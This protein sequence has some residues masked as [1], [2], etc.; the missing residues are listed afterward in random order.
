MAR[1]PGKTQEKKTDGTPTTPPK[2]D[3]PGDT[4]DKPQGQN[5]PPD[6]P[7]KLGIAI[8][9]CDRNW[10]PTGIGFTDFVAK[11]YKCIG[12][13]GWVECDVDGPITFTLH[14]ASNLAG[15]CMNGGKEDAF[16]PDLW[17]SKDESG[18]AEWVYP[19]D[20]G[21]DAPSS[22]DCESKIL[23][24]DNEPGHFHYQWIK[25]KGVKNEAKVT[26]R[27]EDFGAFGWIEATA[28][29]C[30]PLPPRE[31]ENSGVPCPA[32]GDRCCVAMG[33][34]PSQVAYER[35]GDSRLKSWKSS[36]DKIMRSWVK[37]PR[38]ENNNNI[39]DYLVK[40]DSGNNGQDGAERDRDNQPGGMG[41]GDGFTV[42]EEYRGFVKEDGTKTWHHV[43]TDPA[44]KTVFV[45][46]PNDDQFYND[47][48]GLVDGPPAFFLQTGFEIYKI[49]EP[50]K[51]HKF[52]KIHDEN[53]NVELNF[54]RDWAR[55]KPNVKDCSQSAVWLKG[56]PEMPAAMFGF[57]CTAG[58][59]PLFLT[60]WGREHQGDLWDS[61][62]PDEGTPGTPGAKTHCCVNVPLCKKDA[63]HP[64]RLNQI[65]AHE[66]GHAVNL[67]HH[68]EGGVHG[69]PEIVYKGGRNWRGCWTG[70]LTSGDESCVMH[71][72]T[73][74]ST[75]KWW[76]EPNPTTV[77]DLME[78][79]HV[80]NYPNTQSMFG[81]GIP[82]KD[83]AKFTHA[84][85]MPST[86]TQ[87]EWKGLPDDMHVYSNDGPGVTYCGNRAGT[88]DN[89][90]DGKNNAATLGS[91]SS[92][93]KVKDWT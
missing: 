60:K 88:G 43:R 42:F 76:C 37:I 7:V 18:T 53:S 71:Y 55:G 74:I 86:R 32:V 28:P 14:Y 58:K 68:G 66:L 8:T 26:V 63:A 6:E 72:D 9:K 85:N 34:D 2:P 19:P 44:K 67:Q 54:N 62:P 38:D 40:W 70:L 49:T 4:G 65:V 93:R 10:D 69:H 35:Q 51:G 15:F 11:I 79:Q 29:G 77:H 39:P 82:V 80:V 23:G 3:D 52:V 91:C 78:N 41:D 59:V 5:K 33:P 47:L 57:A 16:A 30:L 61:P 50:Y 17:F 48:K 75:I 12:G 21:A 22:R 1:A 90:E 25:T 92:Y 31:D 83:S 73:I 24:Q 27:S 56:R 13:Q 20:G 64:D 45:F 46:I 84:P 36:R 87:G 89:N 81:T